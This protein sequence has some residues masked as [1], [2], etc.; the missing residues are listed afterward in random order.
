MEIPE[1]RERTWAL[2][3]H[4]S[5]FAG[6]FIPFGH[7][8]GPLTI[9][10]VKREEHD[11]VDDQGKESLNFQISV[12]IYGAAAALLVLVVIGIPLVMAVVVSDV[13]WVVIATVRASRGER[14][15]YPLT[16][17]FVK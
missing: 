4:L 11:L 15:R 7:V 12:T 2:F 8:I 14:Y 6:F 13:I 10:L 16:L 5:A 1:S 3:C 9:W 17:R